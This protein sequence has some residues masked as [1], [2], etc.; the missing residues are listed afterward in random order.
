MKFHDIANKIKGC[1][2]SVLLGYY[3]NLE[4]EIG[5]VRDAVSSTVCAFN[6]SP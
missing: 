6:G 1:R 3:M 4:T 5:F 2:K